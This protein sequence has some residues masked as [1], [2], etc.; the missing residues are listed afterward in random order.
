VHAAAYRENRK[1]T[2]TPVKSDLMGSHQKNRRAHGWGRAC[3]AQGRNS[4]GSR[5]DRASAAYNQPSRPRFRP[6]QKKAALSDRPHRSSPTPN[7]RAFP[8]K[9]RL[10]GARSQR[11]G[12]DGATEHPGLSINCRGLGSTK[13]KKPL[14]NYA[15]RNGASMRIQRLRIVRARNEKGRPLRSGPFVGWRSDQANLPVAFGSGEAKRP[16][17][18]AILSSVRLKIIRLSLRSSALAERHRRPKRGSSS[19]AERRS[20]GRA[21]MTP[22]LPGLRDRAAHE[23]AWTEAPGWVVG[24]A[25][26]GEARWF[27]GRPLSGRPEATVDHDCDPSNAARSAKSPSAFS[28]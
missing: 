9:T 7:R 21:I 15:S 5:C 26:M 17:P 23:G 25:L 16:H 11:L 1:G 8:S 12:A 14:W 4:C 13:T 19:F 10:P 27:R 18:A 28:R 24:R 20:M 3:R 22:P 2:T 6:K